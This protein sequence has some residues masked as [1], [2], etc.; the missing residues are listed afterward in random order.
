MGWLPADR[1]QRYTPPDES[2]AS[3][4]LSSEV[5]VSPSMEILLL[6]VSVP[7]YF[8]VVAFHA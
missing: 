3:N 1:F 6:R 8:L 7:M 2:R 5:N 4:A